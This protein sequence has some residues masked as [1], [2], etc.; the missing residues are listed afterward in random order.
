MDRIKNLFIL[1]ILVAATG[2]YTVQAQVNPR[3]DSTPDRIMLTIPGDP[4]TSAAV[5]WRSLYQD[6]ISLGQIAKVNASLSGS[7]VKTISGTFSPWE[8]GSNSAMGHKVLFDQLEPNTQYVYRVGNGNDWSEWIQFQTASDSAEPFSFLY[9]GDI[10]NNI[11]SGASRTLR[12]GYSH[13]PEARFMLFAGDI[14]GRSIDSFWDEFFEAGGWIFGMVPSLP[15]PGN[16]EYYKRDGQFKIFSNQWQQIYELPENGPSAEFDS[17]VYY[18]DYQG[19]RF[20]SVDSQAMLLNEDDETKIL[21]W[22]DQTLASNP[23]RWAVVFAHHPVYSCSQGR[24]SEEYRDSIKPILE[25]H[26]V[27]LML[28][29]HDHAYCR[30]QNLAEVGEGCQTRR[31]MWFR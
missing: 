21:R 18:M 24:N 16:H 9:F 20:I 23:N 29:G 1:L 30:G 2:I 13:L 31:C 26:G 19:V 28:Q 11:R 22:L 5:S 4:A 14:V 10:Q 7:N 3:L 17:R 6:T 25:K 8:N 12:Q 27:D 15:T